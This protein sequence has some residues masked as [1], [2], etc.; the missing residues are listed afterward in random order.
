MVSLN[1]EWNVFIISPLELCSR[2]S[3]CSYNTHRPPPGQFLLPHWLFPLMAST[4]VSTHAGLP[5]PRKLL[6]FQLFYASFHGSVQLKHKL[7]DTKTT[8]KKKK[9][10]KKE[11]E[12]EK[13]RATK[14]K[15]EKQKSGRTSYLNFVL[16]KK[17]MSP[18]DLESHEALSSA[19][20]R[21]SLPTHPLRSRTPL[22]SA[23]KTKSWNFFFCGKY[24][25]NCCSDGQ[26]Y[27][28]SI[29]V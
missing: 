9:E 6:L 29:W 27:R 7:K 10:Q 18:L 12:R 14:S 19:T 8:T 15:P 17:S 20:R 26:G 2:N 5:H 4:S 3:N 21:G 13:G 16:L 24:E 23:S 28:W 25:L 11:K 1:E 22:K